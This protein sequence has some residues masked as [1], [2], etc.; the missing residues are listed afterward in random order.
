MNYAGVESTYMANITQYAGAHKT[1][2][3]DGLIET[4][5]TYVDHQDDWQPYS[6]V[7]TT[8]R[9]GS[10]ALDVTMKDRETCSTHM[11]RL[12]PS[13]ISS[14]HFARIQRPSL[15]TLY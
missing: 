4:V 9:P 10:V 1:I 15:G 2:E 3:S 6:T 14:S 11:T 13:N 12:P 5:G 8:G 7:T